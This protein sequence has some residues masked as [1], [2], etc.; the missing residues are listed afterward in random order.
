MQHFRRLFAR[1][2]PTVGLLKILAVL[3]HR[4]G[5]AV[6]HRSQGQNTAPGDECRVI[7]GRRKYGTGRGGGWRNKAGVGDG[8]NIHTSV[9]KPER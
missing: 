9:V 4:S 1:V 6:C 3:R 2:L 8:P 7:R 5:S